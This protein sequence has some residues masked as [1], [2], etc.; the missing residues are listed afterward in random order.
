MPRKLTHTEFVAKATA[1][2]GGRY[3]YISAYEGSG[4]PLQILCTVH[5]MFLQAPNAHITQKQGCPKCA[6]EAQGARSKLSVTAVVASFTAVHGGVYG[7]EKMVYRGAHTPV[8]ITCKDHGDFMQAPH[9]HRKGRGCPKCA[10]EPQQ[11]HNTR[12]QQYIQANF[13]GLARKAHGSTFDY[14]LTE[15]VHNQQKIVVTC[16][17]HNRVLE[18]TAREHLSGGN[19]CPQCTHTASK[20]E[21]AVFNLMSI[22][23]PTK[24][25]DRTV[26]KPKELDIYMPDAKLAVEYCGEFWHSHKDADDERANKHKHFQKYKD[27]KAQGIRLITL[28]ESEWLGHNYAVRRLLRNAVGKS[29]GKLMARKC[30]LRKATHAEARSFYERYHPQGGAGAGEHYALFWK[31]KMVACMRFVLGANDRGA[32][33]SNRVWTLGRYATRV[34]VAGAASRLF[35]AFVQEH[36]PPTVK[37][38]S[39]NRFFEGGMYEQLGFALEAEVPADYQVWHQKIGMR[40]KS[41]Y[42][43]RLLPTR[44]Q[45]VGADIQFDPETDPRTETDI[46]YAM[47]ARRIYDCGKKRW[48]W[49]APQ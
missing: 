15:Y 16:T 38:F 3:A 10:V 14:S 46:T 5:G 42:Q 19:P 33:A 4:I 7:Y 9:S 13:E 12:R 44:I 18:Q 41:H 39:D 2:H 34:T 35:K 25:R 22:F 21:N 36:N 6:L 32:G 43:R 11:T 17:A 8:C 31:G 28:Y 48:V 20:G 37:S 24:Q 23:T 40:P 30:E 47:G 1:V 29:K 27:C 49:T 26:L 45:E